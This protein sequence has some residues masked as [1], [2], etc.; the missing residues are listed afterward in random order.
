MADYSEINSLMNQYGERIVER[1]MSNLGVYR[2]V[3]G[4]KRRV[5]ATDTLRKSLAYSY[6]QEGSVFTLSFFAK[7]KAAKYASFVEYGVNGTERNNGSPYSFTKG[8]VPFDPIKAWVKEKRIMA[9][10]KDGKILKQT[11]SNVNAM[12]RRMSISIAKKGTRPLFY[13]RDAQQ[14]VIEEFKD[15]FVTT[16]RGVLITEVENQ[17]KNE[18]KVNGI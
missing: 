6:T 3:N 5:V 2:V 9:R 16:L 11:E 8:F 7:G 1:A 14:D 17:I 4:K 12:V 18:L 13:W 10:G 15:S